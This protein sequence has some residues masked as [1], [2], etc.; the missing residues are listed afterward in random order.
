M[1]QW[2]C[3]VA[4][5]SHLYLEMSYC[6]IMHFVQVCTL[7]CQRLRLI[8]PTKLVTESPENCQV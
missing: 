3:R 1:V 7:V 5:G 8:L 2:Y 6:L 4:I